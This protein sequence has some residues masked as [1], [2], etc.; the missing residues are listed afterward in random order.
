LAGLYREAP[1]SSEILTDLRWELDR[2]D[3]R[4][5]PEAASARAADLRAAID[6]ALS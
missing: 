6:A 3:H 1:T 2:L 5:I 4:A